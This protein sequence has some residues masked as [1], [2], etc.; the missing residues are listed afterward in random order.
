MLKTAYDGHAHNK[1]V[2]PHASCSKQIAL[3]APLQ[4]CT[5]IPGKMC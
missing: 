1:E 3:S 5:A 2:L 4:H